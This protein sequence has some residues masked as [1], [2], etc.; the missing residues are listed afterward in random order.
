MIRK[1]IALVIQRRRLSRLAQE[2]P[3][4]SAAE[5]AAAVRRII[6]QARAGR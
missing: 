3:Q 5:H 2:A 6:S 4:Q 1:T